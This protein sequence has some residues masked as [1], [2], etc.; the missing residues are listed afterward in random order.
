[1]NTTKVV[2]AAIYRQG[3]IITRRGSVNLQEG[4]QRIHLKGLSPFL[5]ESSLRLA[6]PPGL[7]GGQVQTEYPDQAQIDEALKELNDRHSWKA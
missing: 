4:S 2:N 3:A 5:D 1:M 6:L 7:S